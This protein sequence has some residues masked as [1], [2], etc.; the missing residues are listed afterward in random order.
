MKH[1]IINFS[2]L[3]K[4]LE[5]INQQKS[6]LFVGWTDPAIAYIASIHEYGCVIPVTQKM[7]GFLA[8]VYGI[9]LKK[10]TTQI[11]IPPRP[12][13]YEIIEKNKT[14]WVNEFK[15]ILLINNFDVAKSF[16]FMGD[17]MRYDYRSVIEQGDFQELSEA[18]LHIRKINGIGGSTPLNATGEMVNKLTY[19][20]SNG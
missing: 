3:T 11:V 10:D 15:K 9:Y 1:N 2:V 5:K 6:K 8:K 7:R 14:K 20:I 18:T 17:I 16:E 19:E 12:H 13:R 4:K